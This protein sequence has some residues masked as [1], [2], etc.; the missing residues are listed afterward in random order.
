MTD[1]PVP[2][3]LVSSHRQGCCLTEVCC[4]SPQPSS[5]D[6][7]RTPIRG[8][9]LGLGRQLFEK[10]L[11]C[12]QAFMAPAAAVAGAAALFAALA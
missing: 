10:D 1:A 12:M 2:Q 7:V 4:A 5:S 9:T 11:V 6:E 8:R 3:L